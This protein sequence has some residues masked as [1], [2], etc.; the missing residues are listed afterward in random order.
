[1]DDLTYDRLN[2]LTEKLP[3]ASRMAETKLEGA[4]EIDYVLLLL[5]F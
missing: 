3:A 5:D 1:M 2:P 4:Q